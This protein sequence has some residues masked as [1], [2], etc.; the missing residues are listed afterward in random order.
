MNVS[1]INNDTVSCIVKLEI[2]KQ[3]YEGKVEKSLRQFR[4]QAT[5][6]GFRKGMVPFGLIK[7]MYGK[8]FLGEEIEKIVAEALNGYLKENEIGFL[9]NPMPSETEQQLINLD[10]QENFEFYFDLALTP[11]LTLKFNKRDRLTR[12]EVIV[13]DE[14]INLQID[15]YR[16]NYGTYEQAKEVQME[17]MVK[18]TVTEV[19]DGK[20]KEGGIVAESTVLIPKYIT[21]ES[22]QSKF[23]GSKLNDTILFNPQTAYKGE[24]VEIA[25]L[26]QITKEVAEQLTADFQFE[27]KEISRYSISEINKELF[28]KVFGENDVETEEQFREKVKT[29]LESL[30][31][32][33]SDSLIEADVNR[34]ITKK[35]GNVPLADSILKRW[36]LLKEGG[37]TPDTIEENYPAIA[38]QLVFHLAKDQ[39]RKENNLTVEDADVDACAKKIAKAQF[40]QYGM[41]SVSDQVLENYAKD[42]LKDQEMLENII[43]RV[44]DEKV[45]AWIKEK[46]KIEPKEVSR[47]EFAK[48]FQ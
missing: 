32:S 8:S 42:M 3:D 48:L 16:R 37:E 15:Y 34:L 40:V 41:L 33:Q 23:I 1:Q 44:L 29:D 27:I 30:Y 6:P 47:D 7:K 11:V 28:D 45:V 43:R 9:G 26:L 22:E 25:S 35:T 18:G 46:V 39:I 14:T 38:K 19:E 13:D 24:A 5:M 2:E 17:D 20:P 21:E 10:E 12:Y 4:Q 31:H 36:L